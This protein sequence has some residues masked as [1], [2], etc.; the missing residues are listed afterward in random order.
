MSDAAVMF[1]SALARKLGLGASEWKT[2]GLLERYGPLTAGDLSARSGLAPPSVTGIIDR[3]E[4]GG[5]VRRRRDPED[6]RRVIVELDRAPAG[7]RDG[8]F[9]GLTRRL[10]ELYERYD[11]EELAMLLEFMTEVAKRQREATAEL[12]GVAGSGGVTGEEG[13]RIAGSERR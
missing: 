10:G 11:E 6:R 2:L 9:A 3:L 13:A 12:E 1:H 4:R 8:A 5:W 7:D